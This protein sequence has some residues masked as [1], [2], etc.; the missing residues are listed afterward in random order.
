[1]KLKYLSCSRY[2]AHA[3]RYPFVGL[4]KKAD[5]RRW[6]REKDGNAANK[7]RERVSGY[8]RAYMPRD[9]LC[10]RVSHWQQNTRHNRTAEEKY[11]NSRTSMY[12]LS[13]SFLHHHCVF[14]DTLFHTFSRDL[15]CLLRSFSFTSLSQGKRG[16]KQETRSFNKFP[17]SDTAITPL[18]SER[19]K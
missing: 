15:T 5:T 16:R 19:A 10:R 9:S 17:G 6:G 2:V 13:S 3:I 1:M 7:S 11:T 8:T 4:R 14:L 18:L 12:P